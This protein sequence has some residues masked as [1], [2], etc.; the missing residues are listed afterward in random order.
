MLY[1]VSVQSDYRVSLLGE[2]SLTFDVVIQISFLGFDGQQLARL[3][4][5]DLVQF[6]P[7][8]YVQT[9]IGTAL[10]M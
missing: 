5:K 4:T 10:G 8:P 6:A 7:G 2:K 1:N 3:A 9:L